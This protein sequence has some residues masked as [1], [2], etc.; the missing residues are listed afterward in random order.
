MDRAV[1]TCCADPLTW[2]QRRR[3]LDG[4]QFFDCSSE[5]DGYWLLQMLNH[6]SK[7]ILTECLSLATGFNEP[8]KNQSLVDKRLKRNQ[9][10]RECKEN[11]SIIQ[12][13]SKS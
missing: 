10:L 4:D 3:L 2:E 5:G 1:S 6:R 9:V 12:K 7:F 11:A 13:S 8:L